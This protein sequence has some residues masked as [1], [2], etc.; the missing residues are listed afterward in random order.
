VC[1]EN[2]YYRHPERSEGSIGKWWE[3]AQVDPSQAQDD[4]LNQDGNVAE[5]NDGRTVAIHVVISM[6]P[7]ISVPR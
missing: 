1:T 7:K 2:A 3:R 5:C 4:V 6:F